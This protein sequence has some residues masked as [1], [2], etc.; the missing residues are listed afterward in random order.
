MAIAWGT[1][2]SAVIIVLPLAESWRTIQNVMIGMFTNDRLVEKIEE[3][4]LKLETIIKAVPDAER[5]YQIEKGKI[6]KNET[7]QLV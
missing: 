6:K 3:L 5:I 1:I 4:N 2:G 7:S